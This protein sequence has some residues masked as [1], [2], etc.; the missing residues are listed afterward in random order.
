MNDTEHAEK[1]YDDETAVGPAATDETAEIA[2][3][4]AVT[5][6]RELAWSEN[7]TAEEVSPFDES[8]ERDWGPTWRRAG[9][10]GGVAVVGAG[11]AFAVGGVGQPAHQ[12]A[13]LPPPSTTTAPPA[14]QPA[15]Q[16]APAPPPVTV[17]APPPVTVT[18]PPPVTIQ[19]APPPATVIEPPPLSATDQQF[20]AVL[21]NQGL[22]YPDPAYA[23]SHAQ[24]VCD[25]MASHRGTAASPSTFVQN[26]TIWT[27]GLQ[28]VE[29]SDYARVS[30][31]PQFASE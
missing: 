12:A 31:C 8:G 20:L 14:A 25:F 17:T 3:A 9:L 16:A 11:L 18:A 29:F 21:H 6:L 24:A 30:Y 2:P 15:P 10:I 4:D 1:M 19:A 13:P 7:D 26:T 22:S 5:Q 28:S 27:G 23:I